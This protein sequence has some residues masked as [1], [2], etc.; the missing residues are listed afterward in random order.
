MSHRAATAVIAT[1]A[2]RGVHIPLNCHS[3][4]DVSLNSP[5]ES[6]NSLSNIRKIWTCAEH[7]PSHANT[8]RATPGPAATPPTGTRTAANSASHH[9][10]ARP[11]ACVA[12]K[13]V[14]FGLIIGACSPQYRSAHRPSGLADPPQWSFVIY[15]GSILSTKRRRRTSSSRVSVRACRFRSVRVG[16]AATRASQAAA[17][18]TSMVY[19]ACTRSSW[20]L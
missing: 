5:K 8:M 19:K 2:V 18:A 10:H 7:G 3:R 1:A 17:F 6:P 14:S 12:V 15:P 9:T 11:L 4:S 16:S 13:P 20:I